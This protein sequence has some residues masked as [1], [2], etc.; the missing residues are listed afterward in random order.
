MQQA[1]SQPPPPPTSLSGQNP[2][3]HRGGP[4]PAPSSSPP[5]AGAKLRAPTPELRGWG[6]EHRRHRAPRGGAASPGAAASLSLAQLSFIVGVA[7]RPPPLLFSPPPAPPSLAGPGRAAAQPVSA[8]R[9]AAGGAGEARPHSP[10]IG[11]RV[12][13]SRL[14][15]S[16]SKR[17]RRRRRTGGGGGALGEVPLSGALSAG[18]LRRGGE[19]ACGRR[20]HPIVP[21]ARLGVRGKEPACRLPA[22]ASPPFSPAPGSRRTGLFGA[23]TPQLRCGG[24]RK[25]SEAF[26]RRSGR[27]GKLLPRLRPARELLKRPHLEGPSGSHLSHQ[28]PLPQPSRGIRETAGSGVPRRRAVCRA[29]GITGGSTA[30]ICHRGEG[31]RG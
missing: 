21:A 24:G 7:R 4:Q 27:G 5:E 29:P 31:G 17:R 13:R 3:E 25:G 14:R 18:T 20:C 28:V 11:R 9:G 12:G 26:P 30:V 2:G 10:Y 8:A 1:T 16:G 19:P 15:G 23:S 22:P 6:G